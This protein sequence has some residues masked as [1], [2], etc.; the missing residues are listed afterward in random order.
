M[1]SF[2]DLVSLI[3]LCNIFWDDL[4][5]VFWENVTCPDMLHSQLTLPTMEQAS[6][7]CKIVDCV[8]STLTFTWRVGRI[9][10]FLADST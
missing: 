4:P 2:A 3:L 1:S 5:F 10:A 6:V 8:T 7:H 9:V